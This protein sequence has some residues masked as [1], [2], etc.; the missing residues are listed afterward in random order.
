MTVTKEIIHNKGRIS[1]SVRKHRLAKRLKMS[2][3]CDGSCTVTLPWRMSI[4]SA[5]NFV[6]QNFE[7]ALEKIEK[8]KKLGDDGGM[9]T[10]NDKAEYLRLKKYARELVEERIEKFN[11]FYGFRYGGISI[12]NQKTRWGSCSSK[13]NLNFNYKIVLL[14]ERHAEYIIV[15]ELCHTKEFNHSKRFWSLVEK[16]IPEYREIVRNLRKV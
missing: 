13:G 9:F 12:R 15:H 8:M 6:R 5:D 3:S 7:W 4:L 14:P 1:Y 2:I 16:T 11:Y 10:K